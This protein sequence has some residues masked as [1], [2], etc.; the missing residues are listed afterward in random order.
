MKLVIDTEEMKQNIQK[1]FE[2]FNTKLNTM[3]NKSK[4]KRE[5]DTIE[6]LENELD[7]AKMMIDWNEKR[8]KEGKDVFVPS[9]ISKS[10]QRLILY[11]LNKLEK[12]LQ[13]KEEV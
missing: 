12:K 13:N 2:H 4:N 9:D 1:N 5:N 10:T 11:G 3:S 6:K 8:I 7:Y